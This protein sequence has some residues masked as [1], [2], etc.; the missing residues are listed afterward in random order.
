LDGGQIL[1]HQFSLQM[2]AFSFVRRNFL[3]PVF[4]AWIASLVAATAAQ[5][6]EIRF[7]APAANWES[8]ALPVGNGRIGAM[9]YGDPLSERMQFNDITLWTGGAN[10]LQ[11]T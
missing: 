6:L 4:P 3:S 5:P 1:V 8:E 11:T 9:I 7:A 2:P 10:P